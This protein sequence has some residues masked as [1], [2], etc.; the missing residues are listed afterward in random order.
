MNKNILKLL[1]CGDN[2]ELREGTGFITTVTSP[3]FPLPY[4][5]DLDCVWNITTDPNRQ[6]NIRF[7]EMKLEAFHDCSADY[8]EFF[9]SSDIMAN[10]TLGKFCGTM[11][12]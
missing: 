11:D 10:K 6:L 12:K 9:D 1:E 3:A 8:I 5:K 4:T 7:E 2:I